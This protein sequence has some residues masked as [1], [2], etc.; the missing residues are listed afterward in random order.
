MQPGFYRFN[1]HDGRLDVVRVVNKNSGKGT[2]EAPASTVAEY[3]KLGKFGECVMPLGKTEGG[4]DAAELA[5]AQDDG[6]EILRPAYANEAVAA[7]K[8]GILA[9][10]L[11]PHWEGRTSGPGPLGWFIG[12]G[13]GRLS[14]WF[15]KQ[16]FKAVF[17]ETVGW[18]KTPS[19]ALLA[20][21]SKIRE[22]AAGLERRAVEV[23]AIRAALPIEGD[24]QLCDRPV[25]VRFVFDR[26][27]EE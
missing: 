22:Q 24:G 14:L 26:D 20:L 25:T 1:F 16:G 17:A 4:P 3:E 9:R 19:A 5:K 13:N 23:A 12:A 2:M 7:T 6:V 15:T 10:W 18:G 21:E 11:G 27:G 8:A